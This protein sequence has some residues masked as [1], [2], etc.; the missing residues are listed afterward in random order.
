M[1]AAPAKPSVYTDV[2]G[3]ITREALQADPAEPPR[4]SAFP[5][6]GSASGPRLGSASAQRLGSPPGGRNFVHPR[7]P[8]GFKHTRL[9]LAPL[10]DNVTTA[11][12]RTTGLLHLQLMDHAADW[13][14]VCASRYGDRS[15]RCW[16]PPRCGRSPTWLVSH[17]STPSTTETGI[18]PW[19]R[20]L[21]RSPQQ[22][23]QA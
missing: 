3:A 20:P 17:R 22:H 4:S 10:N 13:T 11:T 7:Q 12:I 18:R 15:S 23:A 5:H 8:L 16:S 6:L 1:S 19:G 14:A 21:V 2:Y 9:E